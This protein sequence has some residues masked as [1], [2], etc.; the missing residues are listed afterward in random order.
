MLKFY[1]IKNRLVKG[2]LLKHHFH[3][4]PLMLL[5]E[6]TF[7]ERLQFLALTRISGSRNC[8]GVPKP[9]SRDE[10]E[11]KDGTL[12]KCTRRE[13]EEGSLLHSALTA[14]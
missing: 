11:R 13:K 4:F 14:I 7:F 5:K 9:S 2:I 1:C 10:N 8:L 6:G 12:L 3:A